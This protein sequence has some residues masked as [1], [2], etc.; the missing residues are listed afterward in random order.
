MVYVEVT[1]D[2]E[3]GTAIFVIDDDGPGVPEAE[4]ENVFRR[5][6]RS[7]QGRARREMRPRDPRF[8]F[9]STPR[10]SPKLVTTL[11]QKTSMMAPWRRQR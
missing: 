11:S 10:N 1:F 4:R 2:A 9:G 8:D 5:F 6:Y 3:A 7:D